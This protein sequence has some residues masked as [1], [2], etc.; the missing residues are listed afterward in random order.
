M[1]KLYIILSFILCFTGILHDA[2]GQTPYVRPC[3]SVNAGA[4]V[5]QCSETC[6]DPNRTAIPQYDNRATP[7]LF[8]K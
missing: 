7:I 1:K 4:D 3:Y 2:F 6:L 8:N 5:T